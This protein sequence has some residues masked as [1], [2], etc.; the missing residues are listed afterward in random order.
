M[1][2]FGWFKRW[3]RPKDAPRASRATQP[4]DPSTV[5]SAPTVRDLTQLLELFLIRR[6]EAELKLEEKRAEVALKNVERDAELKAKE[7]EYRQKRRELRATQ[8]AIRNRTY[9]RDAK[10]RLAS[11]SARADCPV[12]RD[13]A[14]PTLTVEAIE[15][16]HNEGHGHA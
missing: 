4:L 8:A 3:L 2:M 16:H 6:V 12:C 7:L 15:R 11:P 5:P 10:G 14:S 9:P 1:A 13:P